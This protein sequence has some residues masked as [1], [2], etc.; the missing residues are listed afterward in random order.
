METK[1]QEQ[2][3]GIERTISPSK[4]TSC[5]LSDFLGNEN[6]KKEMH[7]IYLQI[8]GGKIFK[9][10]GVKPDKSF[11]FYGEN[12]TGKT[13]GVKCIGGELAKEGI[14]TTIMNYEIGRFG[15]AY[16]N[17]GSVIMQNFFDKG[18][19]LIEN[20]NSEL[21]KVLYV[22]DEAEVLMG[23]RGNERNGHREDDKVLDTLMLNLQRISDSDEGEY[24]FFMTNKIDLIDE[25]SI[26]SGRVDRKVKF[27]KPD[28]EARYILFQRAIQDIN[29]RAIYS[30][31]RKPDIE[32]LAKYSEGFNCVDCVEIPARAVKKRANE[33]LMERNDKLIP[34]LYVNHKRLLDEVEK[35]KMVY[36]RTK[37]G[38]IGFLD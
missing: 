30:P 22:F 29:K 5:V 28:F 31:I 1:V 26:R 16:I 12:G 11:M 3:K 8:V 27:E 25:A 7:E 4:D 18:R 9:Y 34:S 20:K 14:P 36:L 15:T 17:L 32:Q 19:K 21:K 33:I 2:T 37:K 23:K 10:A 6:T 35:Q 13:F 38:R 24:L